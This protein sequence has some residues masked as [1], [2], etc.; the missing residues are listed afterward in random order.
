MAV[1]W[2]MNRGRVSSWIFVL[3][4]ASA[5]GCTTPDETTRVSGQVTVSGK[6]LPG[7]AVNFFPS[8]G[9]RPLAGA[10]DEDGTY[11]VE[12]PAGQYTVVVQATVKLPEGFQEGD[13]LPPQPVKVPN[14]YSQPKRSPLSVTVVP[15]EPMVKNFELK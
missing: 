8:D 12:L 2:S 10:V 5:W 1:K 15:G 7:G 4:L 6:V 13:P 3:V 11:Q 14:I 9:G